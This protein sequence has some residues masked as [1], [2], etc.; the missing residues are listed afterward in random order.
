MQ[1]IKKQGS[2][3]FAPTLRTW[4]WYR[5]KIQKSRLR[6][7]SFNICYFVWSRSCL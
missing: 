6:F 5:R 7:P 4:R 1:T 3:D 2:Y